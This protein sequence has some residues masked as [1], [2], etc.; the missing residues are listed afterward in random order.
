MTMN[1]ENKYENK[2]M[3]YTDAQLIL[4]ASIVNEQYKRFHNQKKAIEEEFDR[5]RTIGREKK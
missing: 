2:I 4:E 5:R 1:E 3:Q